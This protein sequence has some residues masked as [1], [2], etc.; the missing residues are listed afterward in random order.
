MSQQTPT[1]NTPAPPAASAE[2]KALLDAF[3]TVLKT[4]AEERDSTQREADVRRHAHA[5][6]RLL[7]VA[8]ITILGAVG[9]FLAVVRPTWV[10]APRAAEESLAIKEAS[11]RIAIANA[12]QHVQRFSQHNG[13]LPESLAEAGARGAGLI[14]SRL[15]QSSFR[16]TGE[17]GPALV[18][19]S[20]EEGL[21][22]FLGNSYQIIAR[23]PR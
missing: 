3:D 18:T 12:A 22:D 13:R 5:S 20:S 4:Q 9:A 16:L 15:G 17:N 10:F 14:Y 6:S 19:L 1:P 8:S 21:P 23:R 11:L 2:K 7:F